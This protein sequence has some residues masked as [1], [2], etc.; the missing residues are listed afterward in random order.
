M[1]TNQ[2]LT[3]LIFV[4]FTHFVFAQNSPAGSPAVSPTFQDNNS[5][6]IHKTVNTDFDNNEYLPSADWRN[7]YFI[8]ANGKRFEM[9][10]MRYDAHLKRIE[11]KEGENRYYPK[12]KIIEFGF[13]N[14]DVYQ[15]R[16]KAFDG[17]DED[18]F[19]QVLYSGKTKLLKLTETTISD[20]TPYN[21]AS[22]LNHYNLY[23]TYYVLKENGQFMKSKKIYDGLLK[24]LSDKSED[25]ETF[26]KNNKLKIRDIEPL[27]QVLAHYDSQ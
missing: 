22:K 13:A 26:V 4:L 14:G 18:T 25:I 12:E 17:L 27:K 16:F 11:Y 6:V 1:K 2:S 3:I 23:Q 9:T 10:Q 19:F 8:Q 15:N 20:I 24:I 7:G 21:S 5:L